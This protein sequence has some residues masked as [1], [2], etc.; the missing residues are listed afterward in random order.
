M[1][2]PAGSRGLSGSDWPRGIGARAVE[3]RTLTEAIAIAFTAAVDEGYGVA[4]NRRRGEWGPEGMTAREMHEDLAARLGIGR[5]AAANSYNGQRWLRPEEIEAALRDTLIG[6]SMQRRL[7]P[8]G[9]CDLQRSLVA[10][11]SAPGDS[12]PHARRPHQGGVVPPNASAGSARSRRV[13]Q[14]TATGRPHT[15]GVRDAIRAIMRDGKPRYPAAVKE[16]LRS[17]FYGGSLDSRAVVSV[18]SA[19][20]HL[21]RGGELVKDGSGR[22]QRT[23]TLKE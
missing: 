22:Y 7:L 18:D 4:R 9:S 14:V 15:P 11:A 2:G 8:D 3:P 20:S 19:L 21:A 6:P 10:Y 13:S 12:G 5:D 17:S 16:L 1:G 23:D